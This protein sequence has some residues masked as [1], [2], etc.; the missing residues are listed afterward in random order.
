[1]EALL[2]ISSESK[3][4]SS[5]FRPVETLL[6]HDFH[7]ESLNEKTK[8]KKPK[9]QKKERHSRESEAEVDQA[10]RYVGESEKE[11]EAGHSPM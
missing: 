5:L 11:S 4:P 9:G 2:Q 10:S 6:V 7:K 1:M 3:I 8:R